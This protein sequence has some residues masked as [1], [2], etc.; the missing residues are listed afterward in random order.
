MSR[1]YA[2]Y[3]VVAADSGVFSSSSSVIPNF[4]QKALWFPIS[5]KMLRI[6]AVELSISGKEVDLATRRLDMAG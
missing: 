4:A 6:V 2:P 3:A 5:C 1:R